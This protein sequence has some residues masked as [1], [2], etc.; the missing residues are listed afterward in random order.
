VAIAY[1]RAEANGDALMGQQLRN[2]QQ[3]FINLT[4]LPR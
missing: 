1:T 2:A 4:P 3:V